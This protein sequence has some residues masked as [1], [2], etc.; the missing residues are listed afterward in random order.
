M[1]HPYVNDVA[2]VGR[3]SG[4]VERKTLPSGDMVLE[5]RIVVERP[6]DPRYR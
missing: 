6:P 1:S 2:L 4:A 5:W 3:L